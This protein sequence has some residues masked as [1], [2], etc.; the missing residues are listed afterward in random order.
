MFVGDNKAKRRRRPSSLREYDINRREKE[1]LEIPQR[2]NKATYAV[3][4]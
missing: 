4:S 2:N 3:Y 1:F